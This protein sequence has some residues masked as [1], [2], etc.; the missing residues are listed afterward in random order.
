MLI[1]YMYL[2]KFQFSSSIIHVDTVL[3]IDKF[4]TSP[5]FKHILKRRDVKLNLSMH[6]KL[7]S[8]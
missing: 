7:K 2:E 8:L 5:N 4:G 6:Q 1:F 3:D